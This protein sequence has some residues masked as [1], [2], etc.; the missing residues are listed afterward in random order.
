MACQLHII[1]NQPADPLSIDPAIELLDRLES[2]WS[3]FLPDSDITRIN[4][5]AGAPVKVAPETVSL[6]QTMKVAWD[7]TQGRYD[8]TILPILVANGYGTSRVDPAS[9]TV[10]LPGT[11]GT[12]P[13]DQIVVDP[14]DSTVAIPSGVALDAGGI[15][16]GLAADMAVALL[17]ELGALGAL[18]SIGGDLAV[19]GIAPEPEGWRIDIEHDDPNGTPLCRTMVDIGGVATSSTRSR[20]WDHAGRPRHHAIDPATGSQSDTD[21]AAV[22]VFST[23][24]WSAE[25]F[26]TGALLSGSASVIA[27]LHS[28]ALSGLAITAD[29]DVL[30]TDDLAGLELVAAGAS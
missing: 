13:V 15:G 20:R 18:V 11:H 3:R 29:G 6:V 22:T 2:L 4:D 9:T 19:A 8:P 28:H 17:L 23:T 24:G 14:S 27:Y 25:A 30:R 1:V 10:L 7:L 16:K 21:L 12:G 5:A 26:A